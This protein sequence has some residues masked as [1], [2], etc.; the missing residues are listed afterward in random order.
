MKCLKLR[1][2]FKF[3]FFPGTGI[4]EDT[5]SDNEVALLYLH[6]AVLQNCKL[7]F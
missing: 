4:P 3:A 2:L 7:L 5:K 6:I 1:P